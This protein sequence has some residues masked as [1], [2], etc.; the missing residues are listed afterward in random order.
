MAKM[1]VIVEIDHGNG[2]KELRPC[3]CEVDFNAGEN[4]ITGIILEAPDA[5]KWR[6][7]V[8]NAGTL[9]TESVA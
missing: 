8:D 3:S 1:N 5:G 4:E 9:S 6:L 7:V 2:I